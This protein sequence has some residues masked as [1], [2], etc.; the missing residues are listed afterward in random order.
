MVDMPVAIIVVMNISLAYVPIS[1]TTVA[2]NINCTL[3]VLI[4]RN[5]HMALVAVFLFGLICCNSSMAFKPRGV[6]ALPKPRTLAAI[7]NTIEPIAG[8]SSGTSGKSRTVIGRR[9]WL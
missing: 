6:A 3:E 9:F 2:G 1:P 8:W 7:F 4:A 5:V